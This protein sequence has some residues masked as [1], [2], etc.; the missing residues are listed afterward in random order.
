MKRVAIVLLNYNGRQH[1][2]KCLPSLKRQTYKDF[3]VIF[4]DNASTDDSVEYVKRN[5]PEARII[6]NKR[7]L[8]FAEGN[9]VGIRQALSDSEVKYV[10]TLNNDTELKNDWLE[11]LV[12]AAEHDSRVGACASK[13]LY[14]D[15]RNI[16]DSAGDFYFTGSL[17]VHPRGHGKPDSF[18]K[19]EECL[20]GC[21]AATLYRREALEQTKLG[22]DYFDRD[23]FAYIEDT[24]LSLRIRLAGWKCI[25]VPSA[26]VYHKVSATTSQWKEDTKKFL[27]ARN[28]IFT[29]LKIYPLSRWLKTFKNPISYQKKTASLARL[30]LFYV[31]L[32]REIVWSLPKIFKKRVMIKK[33]RRVDKEIFTDWERRFSVKE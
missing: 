17:K 21:A 11:Q 15:Q 3:Y 29:T 28:R 9:N 23:Y 14:F 32:F 25:F 2:E 1:L 4:V 22:N 20:S 30:V 10:V 8:G 19:Q 7:N 31:R 27:T 5:F 18:F 13:L 33:S 26:V 24:D 6:V 12:A 16:I